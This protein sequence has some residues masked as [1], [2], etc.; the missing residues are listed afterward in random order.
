MRP[1]KLGTVWCAVA[2]IQ[3]IDLDTNRWRTIGRC[4]D[5]PNAIAAELAATR[6]RLGKQCPSLWVLSDT[7]GRW[8]D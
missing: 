8:M 7:R 4:V 6:K 5:T 2:R 1:P 3:V